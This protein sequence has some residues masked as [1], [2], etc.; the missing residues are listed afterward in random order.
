MK[1]KK[2]KYIRLAIVV[3]AV[4]FIGVG[5]YTGEFEQLYRKASMICFECIGIG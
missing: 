2:M 4:A 3:V 1:N 5:I